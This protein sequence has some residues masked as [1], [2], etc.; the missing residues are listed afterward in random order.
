M[1]KKEVVIFV[2]GTQF[3]DGL[4]PDETELMTEGVMELRD[5]GE[6]LVRYQ[7]SELTG[8]EGTTTCFSIRG[9]TVTLTRSGQLNSQMVF[10]KGKRHSSLYETP[11]GTMLIDIS[12]SYLEYRINE[13]GGIMEIKY[14]VAVDYQSTGTNQFKIRIRESMR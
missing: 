8:M 2:R 13:R 6:I 5:D 14:G 7:E 3:F 12:T 10:Q 11:W 1:M 9:D 4:Q